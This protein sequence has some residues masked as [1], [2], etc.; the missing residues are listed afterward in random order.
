MNQLNKYIVFDRDGTLINH[1]PYLFSTSK[2]KI[3]PYVID[4]V[5]QFKKKDID[6]FYILI[7]LE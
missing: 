1:E 3:L 7:N 5:K 6:C 4:V 2:V